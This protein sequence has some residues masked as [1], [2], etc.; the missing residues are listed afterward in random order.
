MKDYQELLAI[1][2]K[3]AP[4]TCVVMCAEDDTVLEGVKLALQHGLVKAELVGNEA[5]IRTLAQRA[6][7]DPARLRITDAPT[8][9]DAVRRSLALMH[10]RGDMLMK[11]LVS[12]SVFLKGVLNK[13]FGLRSGNI[14]SHVAVLQVP[15]YHKLLFMS[16]GGMNPKL[17]VTV[18]TEIIRN[19]IGLLRNLGIAEPRIALVAASETVNPD[20]PETT[21]AVAIVEQARGGAFP[22]A[23]IEGPF[24]F[25]VAISAEAAQ[26][27]KIASRVAGNVD[28]LLMANISA[29][30]CWAKGLIYCA[31]AQAAGIVVGAQKPVIMLSRADDAL[32]KLHSI[33]LGVAA[34]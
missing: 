33:A 13:E 16:D 12:T 20:M 17:D 7:L 19:A 18:R 3:K 21:D 32:V 27:K 24:G 31:Q 30:N 25:D 9:E 2:G 26:H 6:G 15:A 14:L 11:G 5:K 23:I 8:E 1:A 29:A 10:E 22:G 28:F 4:K 34:S